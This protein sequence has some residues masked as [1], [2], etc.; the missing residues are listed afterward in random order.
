MNKSETKYLT[1][2]FYER[3]K[4]QPYH[5]NVKKPN[6]TKSSIIHRCNQIKTV[7]PLGQKRLKPQALH[8]SNKALLYCKN[9][10]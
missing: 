10:I 2:K 4:L 9:R 5:L 6:I 1:K 3:K 7:E 8:T